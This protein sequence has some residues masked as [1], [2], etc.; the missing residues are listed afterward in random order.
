M[1]KPR[2]HRHGRIYLGLDVDPDD[3]RF[4]EEIS[5]REDRPMA[6][7]VRRILKDYVA[8]QRE[9]IAAAAKA[10]PAGRSSD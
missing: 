7:L 2:P 4:L 9:R 1:A 3:Y 5:E 6:N 10:K 8:T